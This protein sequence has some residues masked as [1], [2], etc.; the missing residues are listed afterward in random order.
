MAVDWG[1]KRIGVAV[2][3]ASRT[4]AKPLMTIE[5]ASRIEDA[6]RIAAT[7]KELECAMILVGVTYDTE[8]IL[9]AAGRSAKRLAEAIRQTSN[10]QVELWDEEGSTQ[11]VK[12]TQLE[13]GIPKKKRKGHFDSL[14]AAIF[15][16]RY[17]DQ[18][19]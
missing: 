18:L 9:T 11:Q 7:A 14:A 19:T 1:A 10:M 5:H 3:D 4:I 17:L 8:N 13:L 16:Q 6:A 15:L 12:H 2:S